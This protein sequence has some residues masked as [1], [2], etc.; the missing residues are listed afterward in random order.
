MLQGGLQKGAPFPNVPGLDLSKSQRILIVALDPNCEYCT[1]SLPF[2]KN[3]ADKLRD[4][5][6][7]VRMITV[8][9]SSE[10]SAKRYVQQNQLNV[11]TVFG[12]DFKTLNLSVIP[13]LILIDNSGTVLDFW[14]GKPSKDIEE[15]IINHI[16]VGA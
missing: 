7:N 4:R 10:E 11:E 14:I 15:Q 9:Q 3:L 13:A 5:P 2:F 6:N 8:F 1:E 16:A 12:V